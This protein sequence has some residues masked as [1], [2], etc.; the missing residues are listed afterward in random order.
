MQYRDYYVSRLKNY[1]DSIN[2]K[3]KEELEKDN[4]DITRLEQLKQAKYITPIFTD[5]YG[6]NER[7]R[8]PW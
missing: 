2:N 7:F 6:I 4:P 5:I 8:N 1:T 3:I